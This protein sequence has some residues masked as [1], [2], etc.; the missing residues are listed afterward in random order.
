MFDHFTELK[1]ERHQCRIPLSMLV[2]RDPTA[3][4][5]DSGI[6]FQYLCRMLMTHH[7][8]VMRPGAHFATCHQVL[9]K[10]KGEITLT[11][12]LTGQPMNNGRCELVH[13]LDDRAIDTL[14][15][16]VALALGRTD[17][18]PCSEPFW[19]NI[20]DILA[21]CQREKSH[22]AYI[23]RQR[24]LVTAHLLIFAQTY[25]SLHRCASDSPGYAHI[26]TY[27][28]IIELMA[29]IPGKYQLPDGVLPWIA[30]QIRVGDWL[31]LKAPFASLYAPVS[32]QVLKYHPQRERYAKRL[33]RYLSLM[34]R[35]NKRHSGGV[36]KR[37]MRVLLEQAG[38]KPDMEHPE[39]TRHMVESGLARLA[40]DGVIGHYMVAQPGDRHLLE[41]VEQCA[42]GWWDIY[43]SWLWTVAPPEHYELWE[44]EIRDAGYALSCRGG[45][46]GSKSLA[47]S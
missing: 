26:L 1:E 47:S 41:L 11:V 16:I 19:L 14:C 31:N 33:G 15:A 40:G 3:V 43:A 10:G 39:R 32:R 18:C 2:A 29:T 23:P 44:A 36:V 20:D 25:I 45:S 17:G 42:R 21:L 8:F 37:R 13:V 30:C 6:V 12:R 46:S 35:V 9:P 5:L 7:N 38:I 28:P 27:S 22:R 4:A 24:A 34:F